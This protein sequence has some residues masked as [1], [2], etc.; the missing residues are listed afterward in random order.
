MTLERLDALMGER[1]IDRSELLD[2]RELAASTALPQ[3]TI[4]ALLR[5]DEPPD[6]T[7]NERVRERIQALADAHMKRTGHRMSDLV[8]SI[9]RQLG[10]SAYWARQV[11]SGQKTPSVEFLHGLVSFFRVEG[12]EAFFTAPASEALNRVLMPLVTA[13][14]SSSGTADIAVD[15]PSA[16]LLSR[17]GDVRG[18]ALRKAERLPPERWKVLNATLEALLELDDSEEDQ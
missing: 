13:L 5:G 1:G 6:D 2:P 14:Q 12:G 16:A 18:V 17:Y 7:V 4:R 8:A 11:C 9:S 3:R 15:S 10:V